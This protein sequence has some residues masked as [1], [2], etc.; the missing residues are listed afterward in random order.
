MDGARPGWR[1]RSTIGTSGRARRGTMRAQLGAVALRQATAVRI[2]AFLLCN[3]SV[4]LAQ[5]TGVCVVYLRRGRAQCAG[6]CAATCAC[7][8][9]MCARSGS[10][11]MSRSEMHSAQL[12]PTVAQPGVNSRPNS[13]GDSRREIALPGNSIPNSAANSRA[14]CRAL[15]CTIELEIAATLQLHAKCDE[16]TWPVDFFR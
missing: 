8:R 2:R 14:I 11:S 12:T 10:G 16:C 5:R 9:T 15:L 1:S 3:A 6:P 13:S 4:R 7:C